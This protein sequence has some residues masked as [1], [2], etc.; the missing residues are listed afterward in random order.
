MSPSPVSAVTGHLLAA[1]GGKAGILRL[2]DL[3]LGRNVWAARGHGGAINDVAASPARPSLVLTASKDAS[4]RLWHVDARACLALAAGDG[5][6]RAEVVSCDFHPGLAGGAW[7]EGGVSGAGGGGGPASASGPARERKK[8][9]R[10]R[11]RGGGTPSTTTTTTTPAPAAAPGHPPPDRFVSAGLDGAIK[12]WSLSGPRFA[13]AL[14]AAEGVAAAARARAA[15]AAATAAAAAAAAGGEGEAPP[16]C[17]PAPALLAAAAAADI[18][19][20]AVPDPAPP[21]LLPLPLL[22]SLAVHGGAYVDCVRWL[23]PGA[24]ASKSVHNAILA[25]TADAPPGASPGVV[26]AAAAAFPDCPFRGPAVEGEEAGRRGGG[27]R[28]SPPPPPPPPCGRAKAEAGPPPPPPAP[29]PPPPPRPP[30]WTWLA[31]PPSRRRPR[32]RSPAC[33]SCT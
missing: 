30:W 3:A 5:A 1:T 32:R 12:I 19:G 8:Q 10:R 27:A 26:A 20:E 21:A 16:P 4:L 24:V 17:R 11:S 2:F 29:P 28:A 22:S 33:G 9:R 31:R 23:G 25:W 14:A 15:A 7:G 6:H 18:V 13:A